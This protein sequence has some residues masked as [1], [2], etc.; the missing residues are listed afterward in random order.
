LIVQ[1][2]SLTNAADVRM[3]VELGVDTIGLAPAGQGLPAEIEPEDA[4]E[5]FALMPPPVLG[6]ALTVL[7]DLKAIA[8][9]VRIA[10]P[11]ILHICCETDEISVADQQKMR[12]M[13]P[14]GILIMK[15]I[16]V[17]GPETSDKAVAAAERYAPVSDYLLLDTATP[18]VPG[19]GAAGK[20]HDWDVSARV[21]ER[22]REQVPVI[23]A[24]GLGPA[25]VAAAI[26]HV[27][28]AGVDSFTLT[29]QPGN[30]RRKDRERVKAFVEEARRAA[31]E[32]GPGRRDVPR[33]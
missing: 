6:S 17:G 13:L 25:N 4:R 33:R 21:V 22:V 12:G 7:T 28:P 16:E 14:D 3:L 26:R 24:G 9:M 29:N 31:A 30:G 19:I 2:Y 18:E 27:R 10:K 23:L 8:G 5:L 11:A 32:L 1:I 15:A 20:V